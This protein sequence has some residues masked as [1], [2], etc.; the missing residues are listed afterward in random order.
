MQWSLYA[1]NKKPGT[2]FKWSPVGNY[3]FKVNNRNTRSKVWNMFK[4]NMYWVCT[5]RLDGV[6]NISNTILFSSLWK[7]GKVE[8]DEAFNHHWK[9]EKVINNKVVQINLQRDNDDVHSRSIFQKPVKHL[10]RSLL[11]KLLTAFVKAPS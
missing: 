5:N 6:T 3:M 10:K 8:I 11:R 2:S 1:G 7:I 4:V 9:Q